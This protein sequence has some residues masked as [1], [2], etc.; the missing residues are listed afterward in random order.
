M[1]CLGPEGAG[2]TLNSRYEAG[3]LG[4]RGVI[5]RNGPALPLAQESLEALWSERWA[6]LL[7]G[8]KL[9]GQSRINQGIRTTISIMEK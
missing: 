2:G 9:S 1:F 3:W 4:Y 8:I 7:E 6:E 5:K